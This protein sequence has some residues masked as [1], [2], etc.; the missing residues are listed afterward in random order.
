LVTEK[1]EGKNTAKFPEDTT[2][3][4]FNPVELVRALGTI[5]GGPVALDLFWAG[6]NA[7]AITRLLNP[8]KAKKGW[9]GRFAIASGVSSSWLYALVIRPRILRLGTTQ[10][11]LN[12]V[13]P[14][15][16]LITRPT[17]D[18]TRAITV[19]ASADV[20]YKW[21]IQIGYQRGGWYSFDLLEKLAGA[22]DFIEGHSATRIHPELQNIAVGD[23]VLIAPVMGYKVVML[24]AGR[25]FVLR[26]LNPAN[27]EV[28]GE[29]AAMD[30]TW[31]WIIKPLGENSC[32]I[33]VRARTKIAPGL[34]GLIFNH[35]TELPHFIMEQG[36]LHGIKKLAEKR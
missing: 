5:Y 2:S 17:T 31:A 6:S 36:T 35:L 19:N 18:V 8:S 10:A 25:V 33:I 24:E 9:F 28:T 26:T 3:S 27:G 4:S 20:V 16:E 14:G 32:R 7:L 30:Q 15:D 1:A 23:N 21:L 13:L 12:E 29:G 11:E 22:G 34:V